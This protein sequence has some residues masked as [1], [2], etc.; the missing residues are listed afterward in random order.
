[1]GL[2]AGGILVGTS[3]SSRRHILRPQRTSIQPG[4]AS[5]SKVTTIQTIHCRSPTP[6]S[7]KMASSPSTDHPITLVIISQ[8]ALGLTLITTPRSSPVTHWILQ[9]CSIC[10]MRSGVEFYGN[11]WR[12]N[13]NHWSD[14]L[15]KCI[16]QKGVTQS[17]GVIAYLLHNT[18]FFDS[19]AS[20]QHIKKT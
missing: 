18:W 14:I 11:M 8:K 17:M 7:R 9:N 5:L 20:D 2:L 19:G 6:D 3:P 4:K 13:V 15:K 10:F 1:M 16:V 12:N